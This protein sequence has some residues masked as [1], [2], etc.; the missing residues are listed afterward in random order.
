MRLDYFCIVDWC[1]HFIEHSDWWLI[2]C[3]L[4]LT[5]HVYFFTYT[6]SYRQRERGWFQSH[7]EHFRCCS[8]ITGRADL[9][10]KLLD[11]RSTFKNGNNKCVF[12]SLIASLYVN[13]VCRLISALGIE[14]WVVGLLLGQGA[15]N[16]HHDIAMH[17]FH[18]LVHLDATLQ[19]KHNKVK[20]A[21]WCQNAGFIM[22]HHWG[23][24][25]LPVS[26]GGMH[27]VKKWFLT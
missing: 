22:L 2:F 16:V 10:Q 3:R 20:I 18:P 24:E 4:F 7:R 21:P 26:M 15:K 19:H 25:R 8:D 14:N 27:N 11:G 13:D 23:Y 17:K 6:Y 12:L 5:P 1:D 9:K